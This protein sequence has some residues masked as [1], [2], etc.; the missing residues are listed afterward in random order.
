VL[1]FERQLER[2]KDV[3][4]AFFR[5][6]ILAEDRASTS[7]KH[8]QRQLELARQQLRRRPDSVGVARRRHTVRC[9]FALSRGRRLARQWWLARNYFRTLSIEQA[10]ALLEVGRAVVVALRGPRHDSKRPIS[11]ELPCHG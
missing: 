8:G 11:L 6:V 4:S 7:A 2:I 5:R 9:Q 10:T 1:L 3:V